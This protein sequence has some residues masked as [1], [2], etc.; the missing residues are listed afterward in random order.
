M[1]AA[2][3]RCT[4]GLSDRT[5][6]AGARVGGGEARR[7]RRDQEAAV[8]EDITIPANGS[9]SRFSV[10]PVN[11][12]SL[13]SE[14]KDEELK[15]I[16]RRRERKN[17]ITCVNTGPTGM[18]SDESDHGAGRGEA[19]YI[20][21]IKPWRSNEVT[22]VLRV[23]DALHLRERYGAARNASRGAWPHFRDPGLKASTSGPRI[24]LPANAYNSV[25]LSQL[26]AWKK[27]E[28][29][30]DNRI[31]LKIPETIK[32]EAAK[33]NLADRMV[34]RGHLNK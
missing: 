32:S 7:R 19:I 8:G 34:A 30:V 3:M 33:Y 4:Q 28:L 18:S 29:Q 31:N 1:A 2:R 27:K 17:E 20:V 23:L 24:G 6:R 5:L 15:A 21:N 11:D 13:G 9:L 12:S 10:R 25:W 22:E 14:D 16:H 26:P